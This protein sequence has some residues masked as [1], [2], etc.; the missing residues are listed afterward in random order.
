VK[1][2]SAL[3]WQQGPS[4]LDSSLDTWFQTLRHK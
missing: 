2:D 3:V 4:F 1:W